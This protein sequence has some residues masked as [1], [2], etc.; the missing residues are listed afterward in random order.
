MSSVTCRSSRT[1][2]LKSDTPNEIHEDGCRGSSSAGLVACGRGRVRAGLSATGLILVGLIAV[3]GAIV[4]LAAAA[5]LYFRA[6]TSGARRSVSVSFSPGQ[7]LGLLALGV[8]FLFMGATDMVTGTTK[9][10]NKPMI[11]KQKD[12]SAFWQRVLL[13]AGTGALLVYLGLRRQAGSGKSPDKTRR[14]LDSQ[15]GA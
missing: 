8:L 11:A 2:P 6:S 3:A 7:R 5:R 4:L 13:Q 9:P 14:D 12:P 1:F 10:S 15:E